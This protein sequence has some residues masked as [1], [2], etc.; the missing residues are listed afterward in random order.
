MNTIPFGWNKETAINA[1][2][3]PPK[4]TGKASSGSS[5]AKNQDIKTKINS[6]TIHKL[7]SF[8]STLDKN[9]NITNL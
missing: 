2:K 1:Q 5:T 4:W 7:D 6:A 3:P 8:F 9:E